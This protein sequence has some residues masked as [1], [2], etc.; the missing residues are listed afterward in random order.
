V[1]IAN[2]AD[3]YSIRKSVFIKAPIEQVFTALSTKNG[4]SKWF[5]TDSEMLFEPRVGGK[6][7]FHEYGVEISGEVLVFDPPERLSFSWNQ[8]PPG[9]PEPT[10]VNFELVSEGEGTRVHVVHSGFDKLPLSIRGNHF[11]G[12]QQGYES[13][14]M[15]EKLKSIIEND[16]DIPLVC[17]HAIYGEN[18][19]ERME[20]R[21]SIYITTKVERVWKTIS[22]QEG[23]R[24]WWNP[25]TEFDPFVG[26]KISFSGNHRGTPY[27][28]VGEII[29]MEEPYR[30]V[31]TWNSKYNP[32]P[33]ASL[34]T[35]TIVDEGE[36]SRITIIHHGFEKMP[37]EHAQRIFQAFRDGWDGEEVVNL[38]R[39]L[40]GVQTV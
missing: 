18:V 34:L 21:N 19:P 20:I 6:V 36:R 23:L 3:R 16:P 30:L 26:G 27:H 14:E 12:Y 17:S 22:T 11:E 40:E 33:V 2:G 28:F 31:F 35:I 9:Y 37:Y 1:K 32:W 25:N 29:E 5:T 39:F 38:K 8:I 15:F 10:V 24:K 7:R 4:L 13:D